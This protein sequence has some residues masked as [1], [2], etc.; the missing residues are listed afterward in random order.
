MSQM[1][2]TTARKLFNYDPDTG[3]LTWAIDHG[4]KMKAGQRA[5]CLNKGY[6]C[7]RHFGQYHQEHRVIWLWM[8]G[9]YPTDHI[10]HINGI[11]DDNRWCNLRA[12]SEQINQQ[13]KPKYSNNVSGVT[14]V[15]WSKQKLKWHAYIRI[16]NTQQHLGFFTDFFE[17]VCIRKSAELHHGFHPNHGR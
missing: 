4:Y 7:I 10:D 8:T 15:T 6:R 5:G 11:R 14:G 2:F 12:V 13:N 1:N 9:S 16:N 17:A 3:I